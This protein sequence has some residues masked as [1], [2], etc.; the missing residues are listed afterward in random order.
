MDWWQALILGI[1]QGLT[2]FLPVSSSGHLIIARDLIGVGGGGYLIFDILVHVATLCAVAVV[3]LKDIL[4]LFKPPF[5]ILGFIALA[6][7]PAVI[8]GFFLQ[9]QIAEVFYDGT[10]LWIFFLFTAVLL[11]AA[12]LIGKKTQIT[13]C[14]VQITNKDEFLAGLKLKHVVGMGLM[15]G[16]AVFPGISRSGSTLFGG[17]IT[18]G[19][20]ETVAKFS[21]FMSVPVI[22][23]AAL[24]EGIEAVASRG[25]GTAAAAAEIPWYGYALAMASAFIVGF[26]AI[27][28]MLRVIAKA[29]YKWFS[30]YLLALSA[31]TFFYYF[32]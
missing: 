19:K 31:F 18:K 32:L 15:Q 27:K 12:E 7:I 26:F 21:F 4:K 14:K 17:I 5:K 23:G 10:Y 1:T 8:T 9:S 22:L 11:F 3:F 6:S 25:S 13:N 30:L 16:L 20:R 29:D 2:E 24:L 28:L